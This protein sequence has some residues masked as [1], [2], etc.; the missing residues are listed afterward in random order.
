MMLE[1]SRALSQDVEMW[2]CHYLVGYFP[3]DRQDLTSCSR[4]T[5]H[6]GYANQGGL[7][8]TMVGT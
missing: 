7:G 1:Y 3:W 5:A 2:K 8:L 6:A 4:M